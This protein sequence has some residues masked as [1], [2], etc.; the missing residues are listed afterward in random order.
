MVYLVTHNAR[1]RFLQKLQATKTTTFYKS[2]STVCFQIFSKGLRSP[3]MA[4]ENGPPLSN[5]T[6]QS[7]PI[8]SRRNCVEKVQVNVGTNGFTLTSIHRSI[9]EGMQS[10]RSGRRVVN[11]V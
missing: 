6:I 4:K 11:E 8:Q 10:G 1:K 3:L 9:P 2:I 5:E 7:L